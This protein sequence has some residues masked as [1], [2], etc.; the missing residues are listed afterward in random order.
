MIFVPFYKSTIALELAYAQKMVPALRGEYSHAS[1]AKISRLFAQ[2]SSH[3]RASI[4]RGIVEFLNGWSHSG[5]RAK[6]TKVD[7][8]YY[9]S[10][11]AEFVV[12]SLNRFLFL[13]P[14]TDHSNLMT[15]TGW[16]GSGACF[17]WKRLKDGQLIFAGP[18]I[19]AISSVW[20]DELNEFDQFAKK[21]PIRTL[22][23][24]RKLK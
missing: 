5:K 3:D 21:Y 20:T 9:A 17:P 14:T 2:I 22:P 16:D 24:G 4:R 18:S 7:E 6:I 8:S 15:I 10:C 11:D 23:Y 13:V 19:M 12:Y 1:G